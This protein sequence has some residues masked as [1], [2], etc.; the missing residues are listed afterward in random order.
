M[1]FTICI[2]TSHIWA[3]GVDI[4]S[5]VKSRDYFSELNI[6]TKKLLSVLHFN[7]NIYNC[8]SGRDTHNKP[9]E[10]DDA[11]WYKYQHKKEESGVAYFM[12]YCNTHY[13]PIV[14]ERHDESTT[15]E[16]LLDELDTLRNLM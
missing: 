8:G 9:F 1:L 4:S 5:Y 2:D 15:N 7:A 16:T 11:I 10:K 12:E 6:I 3:G 14:C 13:I